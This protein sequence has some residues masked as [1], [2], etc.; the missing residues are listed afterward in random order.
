MN[1]PVSISVANPPVFHLHT[2]YQRIY[3][4]NALKAC[5]FFEVS[6][7]QHQP[8]SLLFKLISHQVLNV[9]LKMR[10]VG[11]YSLKIK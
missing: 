6:G 11:I 9:P 8:V 2:E 3:P 4:K 10:Q 7:S 5:L 1:D